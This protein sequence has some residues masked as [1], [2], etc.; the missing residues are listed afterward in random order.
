MNGALVSHAQDATLDNLP[1]YAD[2]QQGDPYVIIGRSARSLLAHGRSPASVRH[3]I[4]ASVAIDSR[5]HIRG[6]T[7]SAVGDSGA[8]CFSAK[9]RK[10]IG[11]NVGVFESE[12]FSAL[13][14]AASI[15]AL[16]R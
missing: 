3:G 7:P 10:L 13:A 14:P 15:A 11:V 5:G 16:I 8:G 6:D 1:L 2:V 9:R 4:V 12:R